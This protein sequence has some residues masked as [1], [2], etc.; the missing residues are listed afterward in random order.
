MYPV[1]DIKFKGI[2]HNINILKSYC[3]NSSISF[4]LVTKMLTGNE[5]LVK[6]ILDHSDGIFSIADSRIENLKLFSNMSIEKWLIRSPMTDE[7]DDTVLFSDA[8]INSEIETIRLLDKSA[9]KFNKNH[10]VILMTELGD[11]RDG[12]YISELADIISEC[13]FF[14]NIEI[15]GICANL[16]CVNDTMPN[17]ENMKQFV[18]IV[19]KIE[20]HF[21]LKFKIVSFGASS[22]IP[23]L[24]GQKLLPEIN[25][26]RFGEGVYLGN[27][28]VIDESFD[29]AKTDNF[30]LKA[31]VIECKTKPSVPGVNINETSLLQKRAIVALGKQDV[32]LPGLKCIDDSCN[33]VGGS[34]DH[35]I[36]DVTKMKHNIEVGSVID[37]KMNYNCL[38][39]A[40]NSKYIQKRIFL[41]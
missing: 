23:L 32:Y 41:D 20:S 22:A 7:T 1:I 31:Q 34:S 15:Y 29:D 14:E 10:K 39:N 36:V 25:N 28:P 26:L 12:C 2:L 33:I 3:L 21:N 5:Y 30:I 37:F 24:T 18:D 9:S 8:S 35:I 40:M 6:N 16:S 11:L 19:R 13:L 17:E 38:L 4:T 27:I